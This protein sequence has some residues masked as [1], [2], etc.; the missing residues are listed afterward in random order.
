MWSILLLYDGCGCYLKICQC[1]VSHCPALIHL[2]ST[3]E[4]LIGQQASDL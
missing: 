4:I 1:W 3:L 2:N